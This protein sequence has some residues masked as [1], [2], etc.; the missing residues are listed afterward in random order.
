MARPR[1]LTAAALTVLALGVGAGAVHAAGIPDGA[2]K[3]SNETTLSRYANPNDS[4]PIRS[5]PDRGAR[6]IAHLKINTEDRLPNVYLVLR[7]FE[8][9][10]AAWY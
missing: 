3:I 9:G 2:S 7:R 6:V 4:G 5:A 8:D 10:G 1:S